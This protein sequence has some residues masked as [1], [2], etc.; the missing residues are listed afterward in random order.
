METEYQY[1]IRITSNGDSDQYSLKKQFVTE[2]DRNDW[3]NRFIKMDKQMGTETDN[4]NYT[5][6][7]RKVTYGDW[8][9]Y[10]PNSA[11]A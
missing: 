11:T 4:T 2:K 8:S 9:S 6:Q 1:R 7:R 5:V 3:I 10:D